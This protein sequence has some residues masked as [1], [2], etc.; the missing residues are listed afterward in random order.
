MSFD[1]TSAAYQELRSRLTR[2]GNRVVPFV[3]A[4][5]SVYGPPE[6][7]LPLWRELMDRL[8]EE[9]KE[10]GL[11]EDGGDAAYTAAVNAGRYIEAMDRLIG[12]L[13]EPNFKRIV[14][15]ELDDTGRP[16]PPAVAELVAVGWSLIVT[17]NLDRLINRAYFERYGKPPLSFT[18]L[19]T[20]RL[21]AAMAGTLTSSETVV[22][23]IHGSLDEYRSW[24]LSRS[25]Y[26]Q[27]LE[28]PRYVEAL[29]QLFL[30][31][32]FFIGFGLQDD[33]LNLLF[34]TV[35]EIYPEGVGEFYALLPRSR[36]QDPI[37]LELIK[38]N[39]LRPIFYEVGRHDPD[40]PFAGHRA[41][42][43]C[44]QDLASEWASTG[45]ALDVRLKYFPELDPFVVGRRVES[46]AL[47]RVLL[48]PEGGVAQLV[49][50]GG[51]GKTSVVQQLLAAKAPDLIRAGYRLAFGCSFSG[52][53]VA[54][55]VQDLALVSIGPLPAPLP[56]QVQRVCE[57][58]RR[59]RTVLVLDGLEV[60]V[61]GERR[62][63]NAYLLELIQ[64]VVQGRGTV[65][66][67]SRVP[68]VGGDLTHAPIIEIDRL[69]REEV[70]EFLQLWGLDGLGADAI[71][72]LY[73][74][75]AGHPLAL[76]VLAGVLSN[77]PAGDAIRTIE[78]S[79]V[80]DIADEVDPLR[81]NRLSRVL[82]AYLRHLDTAEI[83]MLTAASVFDEPVPYPLFEGALG[84]RY[85]GG[86]VTST[87]VDRDLRAVVA[88]LLERRLLTVSPVGE[89][90]C[91]PTVREYFAREAKLSSI[92]LVPIH[93][94]VTSRLL[95]DAAP[96]ALTVTEARPLLAGARHAAVCEDW[97]LFDD[98]FRRRLMREP[99]GY[100]C[101][102]LGAW[103][104]ALSL[105]RLACNSSY[106]A[107]ATPDPAYYPLTA[108]R[109][110]KH[111]GRSSESRSMSIQGLRIAA[112]SRDPET[113][114]YV[115]SFLT[116][117][118]WRGELRAADDLAELNVR[119]LSWIEEEWRHRWQVEHGFS[120][121]A[122]LRLLQGHPD[123][124]AVMFDHSE[125]AWDDYDEERTWVW[126]YYPFHRSEVVLLADP[127]GH[128][129]ALA[130][131]APLL[132]VAAARGWPEP[133]CRGHLQAA[134]VHLDRASRERDASS[135]VRARQCLAEASGIAVGMRVPDV[136][137]THRL[138]SFR[139]DLVGREMGL[140][141]T[142]D[143][144]A[145]GEMLD[146]AERTMATSGLEL[147]RPDLLAA[148]GAAALLAGDIDLA[149]EALSNALARCRRQGNAWAPRS[150]RSFVRWLSDRL[151]LSA[152][153]DST[154]SAA[155]LVDLV[156]VELTSAWM[157][158]SLDRV[159]A[160][161]EAACGT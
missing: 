157:N 88:G 161:D 84:R 47:G 152:T 93:R 14:E 126:D 128:D 85:P 20:H 27:M 150:P 99:L 147:A 104:E 83:A 62:V 136:S 130:A 129:R 40:D 42:F 79:G 5:L 144:A 57:H 2:S 66:V 141:V 71:G 158:E 52:A 58:L 80:I 35:A 21:A 89:I 76:R 127:S 118:I 108:A 61:D 12:L 32:V 48:S 117:L 28:D 100:L 113:A 102:Y 115:N 111:L 11:I 13:G 86:G 3:G 49:G 55:L 124:A 123:T 50:L 36:A 17:T 16:V 106:P 63:A 122:Y 146:R 33:D 140:P 87:L 24:R 19:D 68:V 72:R 78:S 131:I 142:L 132:A 101:D 67:T 69:T 105:A 56:E 82:G 53:D 91:H 81:E 41:V 45:Q 90:S 22:A 9:G 59:E 92:D 153:A 44:L 95:R 98:V 31:Q 39:G 151:D 109:C 1:R 34:A 54:Q 107:G 18:G 134:A 73:E 156:G 121:I 143:A 43:E 114:M 51:S 138:V 37:V 159:V 139:A 74:I 160:D 110:L 135:L 149:T 38:R 25:H 6:R 7:R 154:G 103:D 145:V 4:G 77:V 23:Q 60:L 133:M 30:R 26:D 112:A 65:I 119:A 137:I 155:D 70:A 148:R 120:S 8:S 94:E 64:S 46:E 29:K 15:R 10:I 96:E 125:H 97:T 75:T 116:L